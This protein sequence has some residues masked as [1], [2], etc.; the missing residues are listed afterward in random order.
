MAVTTKERLLLKWHFLV[1]FFLPKV[2]L[3]LCTLKAFFASN[4]I[5]FWEQKWVLRC[6]VNLTLHRLAI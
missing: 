6:F 4:E 5:S 3:G 2:W 1:D